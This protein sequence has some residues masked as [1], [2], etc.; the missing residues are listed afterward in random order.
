MFTLL[1][2]V[3]VGLFVGHDFGAVDYVAPEGKVLFVVNVVIY[4]AI[5]FEIYILCIYTV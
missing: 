1:F 2:V 3:N 5:C 4:S